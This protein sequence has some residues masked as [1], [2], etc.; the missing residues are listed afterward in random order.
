MKKALLATVLAAACTVPQSS[1]A[2]P[3]GAPSALVQPGPQESPAPGLVVPAK[4]RLGFR[5][6]THSE[7]GKG[8]AAE[9]GGA[10]SEGGTVDDSHYAAEYQDLHKRAESGDVEAQFL[11]G[12]MLEEGVGVPPSYQ[13][14]MIWYRRAAD[15]GHV[16]ATVRV[17]EMFLNGLGVP[18]SRR[19]AYDWFLQAA[20][21]GHP[22][23]MTLVGRWNLEGIAKRPDFLTG[24]MWLNK[25]ANA[26]DAEAQ[27]L[28]DDLAAKNRPI[29]EVPGS[30][31][32]TEEM[33]RAVLAEVKDLIEPLLQAP[34]GSTRLKMRQAPAVARTAEGAHQVTLPMLELTSPQGT[35][36]MGTIQLIFTPDGDDYAVQVKLPSQSRFLASDGHDRGRLLLGKRTVSGKWSASL[37]TLTDYTAELENWRYESLDG[38][39]FTMILDRVAAKRVFTPLGEGRWDIAET[40][41][42]TG[43]RSES[44]IGADKKVLCLA[45]AA[46]G[47]TYSGLD[48]LTLSRVAEQFGIDWRTYARRGGGDTAVPDSLPPLLGGFAVSLRLGEMVLENAAGRRL[49]GLGSGELA[50]TGAALDQPL[51]TLSLRYGHA[52]LTSDDPGAHLPERVE[53]ALTARRVPVGEIIAGALGWLRGFPD[54]VAK[55]PARGQTVS[56]GL[57][58]AMAASL[59]PDPEAFIAPLRKEKSELGLD[60]LTL[61]GD[62]YSVTASGSVS[63]AGDSVAA[64]L[65]VSVKGMDKLTEGAAEDD[66][67]QDG[68][69]PLTML[70]RIKAL[71]VSEKDG[72][73]AEV[74]VFRLTYAPDGKITVNGKDA[75]KLLQPGETNP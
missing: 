40:S 74:K 52:G 11:L 71:A 44:G 18:R 39:A 60:S 29:L 16:E 61:S 17:G 10:E 19:E 24:K 22:Q 59:L 35:W 38:Q 34:A 26:G 64:K 49:G 56:T 25:A 21:K 46:Y 15:R 45:N 72:S 1:D 4:R 3:A 6:T 30:T 63:P 48:I 28:I 70:R 12:E 23:A 37:H 7:S 9:A 51:S 50:W 55:A 53:M 5:V 66:P 69:D 33:A 73:G 47:V 58:A 20:N 36:R 41:D 54:A 13:Q 2:E 57:P 75:T 65:T 62:G 31:E 42:I 43:I 32:P 68:R 67:E 14:A 8:A 27:T